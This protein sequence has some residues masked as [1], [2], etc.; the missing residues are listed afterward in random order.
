MYRS[1]KTYRTIWV[2]AFMNYLSM[3]KDSMMVFCTRKNSSKLWCYARVKQHEMLTC[4]MDC[5]WLDLLQWVTEI[6]YYLKINTYSSTY[7]VWMNS[8][9]WNIPTL[10]MKNTVSYKGHVLQYGTLNI[11]HFETNCSTMGDF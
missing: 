11:A 7:T 3:V 4:V 10:W 9:I 5:H 1:N 6:K 2:A 8:M